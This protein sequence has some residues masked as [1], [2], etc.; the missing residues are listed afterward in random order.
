MQRLSNRGRKI[1]AESASSIHYD[2]ASCF[3]L[4]VGSMRNIEATTRSRGSWLTPGNHFFVAHLSG[5]QHQIG[6]FF[7]FFLFFV[8]VD[9]L[10]N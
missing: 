9:I 3:E 7:N 1:S 8:E 5:K 10:H 6:H 4:R 2:A